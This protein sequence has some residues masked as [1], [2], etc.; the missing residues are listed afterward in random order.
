MEKFNLNLPSITSFL[1]HDDT[2]LIS[3]AVSTESDQI[4]LDL[5]ALR[6]LRIV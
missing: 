2:L 4:Q 1:Y 6:W 3:F 5:L